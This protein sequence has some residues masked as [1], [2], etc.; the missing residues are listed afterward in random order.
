MYNPF[1]I[2]FFKE[3]ESRLYSIRYH[4]RSLEAINTIIENTF[5]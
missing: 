3:Y 4:S 5:T 1:P 2:G